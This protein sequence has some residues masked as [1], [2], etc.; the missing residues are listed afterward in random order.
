[1]RKCKFCQKKVDKNNGL[2]VNVNAFCNWTCVYSYAKSDKAK[3]EGDKIL[4]K[5]HA[6]RKEKLKTIPQRLSEAQIAFNS[7]IR[8]RDRFKSCVSCGKPPTEYGRGGG[9][10]ASHYLSRGATNGGSYRRYDPLNVWAACKSCNRY[11]AG[12]LVPYRVE[13]I[14][15]I[16][17]K[18]VEEIEATNKIKKWNHTDLRRIKTIFN[19]K[20]KLYEQRFR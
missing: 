2:V 14:K 12:N 18:R 6:S 9:I 4:R 13:L 8:V 10:D 20:R 7:Y 11:L 5:E 19:K 15:R 17:I 1:M 3:K 16:G